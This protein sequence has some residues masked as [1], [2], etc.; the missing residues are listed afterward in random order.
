MN[1]KLRNMTSL[2]LIS[3]HHVLLLYRVGS[4]VVSPSWCGIGGH[5]EACELNDPQACVLREVREEIGLLP[6]HLHDLSLRYITLR[7]KN[8]EVR[9]NYYY[10]AEADPD[11]QIPHACAEGRLEWTPLDQLP[12][13]EMPLT[14]AHV[15]EHYHSIGQRTDTLYG[16]ITTQNG[17]VF[18]P[19]TDF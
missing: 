16:G 12:L 14:A 10:F 9:Q 17:T 11:V 1:V 7:L 8:G 5:F 19:L 18:S 3:D 6:A 15:L 13:G 2:Y 4:R